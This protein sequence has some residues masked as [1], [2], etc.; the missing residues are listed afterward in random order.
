LSI[1]MS[2]KINGLRDWAAERTVPAG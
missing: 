1:L 2:E